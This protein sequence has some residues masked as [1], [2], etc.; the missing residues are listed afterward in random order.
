MNVDPDDVIGVF[1]FLVAIWLI[2]AIYSLLILLWK[3][4]ILA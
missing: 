2:L 3:D 4:V 1:L